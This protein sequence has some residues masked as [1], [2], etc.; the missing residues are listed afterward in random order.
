VRGKGEGV[1]E[2]PNQTTA[3]ELYLL[4]IIQYSLVLPYWTKRIEEEQE[5]LVIFVRYFIFKGVTSICRF[6]SAVLCTEETSSTLKHSNT[7]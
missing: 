2:E 3:T 1:G 4:K 6:N 7:Q 5:G